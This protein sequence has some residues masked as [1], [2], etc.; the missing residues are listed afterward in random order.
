MI[1]KINLFILFFSVMVFNMKAQTVP[2]PSE[3]YLN[4]ELLNPQIIPDEVLDTLTNPM[5]LLTVNDT[6]KISVSILLEDTNV[7][8]KIHVKLGTTLGSNNLLE[9]AFNYDA[10]LTLPQS[11]FREEEMINIVLGEYINSGIFYCQI[12]LEDVE[13]NLSEITSCQ[14]DQ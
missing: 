13:G 7:V 6:L 9:Q 11:Y 5:N 4:M 3:I 1:K 14:S 8:S 2:S 10:N 12:I